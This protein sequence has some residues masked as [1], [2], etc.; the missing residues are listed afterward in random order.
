MSGKLKI[1]VNGGCERDE[2]SSCLVQ[3]SCFLPGRDGGRG[4]LK[5]TQ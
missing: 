1:R 2:L 4:G 5:E 3:C